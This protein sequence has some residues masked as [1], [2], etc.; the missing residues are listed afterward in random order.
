MKRAVLYRGKYRSDYGWQYG[1]Y[2]NNCDCGVN[3]DIIINHDEFTGTGAE[4]QIDKKF[5][6]QS[7]GLKDKHGK[8]IFEDDILQYTEH[9]G[10]LFGTCKMLVCWNDENAGF[11]YKADSMHG[12]FMSFW[13]H[14]ELKRDVLDHCEIIGNIHDNP[15]LF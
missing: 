3:M 7:T 10:Y 14:D 6:G 9:K 5:L 2:Y 12:F 15:E 4:F 1:H 11:G 8:I 13:N